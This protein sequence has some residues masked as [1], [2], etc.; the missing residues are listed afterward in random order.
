[1]STEQ[2]GAIACGCWATEETESMRVDSQWQSMFAQ[3]TRR[4]SSIARLYV[5]MACWEW[6]ESLGSSRF[7][8]RIHARSQLVVLP[9]D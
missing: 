9:V 2:R 4:R 3:P 7:I 8:T 6:R 5:W 1:M